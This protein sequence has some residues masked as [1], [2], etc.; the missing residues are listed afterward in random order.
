ML[1]LYCLFK[2]YFVG[3]EFILIF[4][5]KFKINIIKLFQYVS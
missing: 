3:L 4:A 1:K 2:K 5:A